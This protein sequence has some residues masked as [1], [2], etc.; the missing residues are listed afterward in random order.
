MSLESDSSDLSV[1]LCGEFRITA[2]LRKYACDLTLDP[3]TAN[4]YLILS[5]ENR[6]ITCM[7]QHQSYP[8]HPERFDECPQVLCGESLTGRCYWEF[9]W[10]GR[11]AIISVTYK[12]ISRKESRDCWFG[13]NDKSWSLYCSDYRFTVWHNKNFT[14]IPVICS[15]SKRVGVYVD[16]SAGTLSFYS[17]S[18][19][20]TLAHLHTF[21]TTFTEPL[22]AGFRLYLNSIVSLCDIKQPPVRN[23]SDTHTTRFSDSKPS[24]LNIHPLLNCQSCVHIADSDQWVQIEPSACTDEGGSKFRVSTD[25]GRYE[26]VRTRMRWVCDCDVTLQYCTVDGH[27]LNTELERLQCN[28]I[29]PVID[30]TVISGKLEEVHLPHYACLGESDPS[31]KDAVKVLTVKD[32]GITT[33]PVQL[34]R[35]HAK[36]VQPSFSLT[37]LIISWIMRVDEHCDLLLYMHSKVPL[38]LHVYFFPFDDC[39][40]EKVEKSEKSSY[41]IKHPRP[42]RPFRMK[43]PH[44]LDVSDALT[45]HPKEGITLRRET[46]PNYFKVTTRL[47][48]DLQMTLIRKE[49]KEEVWTAT[50]LKDELYRINPKRDEP[51]LNSEADKALFFDNHWPDLIQGVKNVGIIADRLCQQKIIHEEQY[52]EITQSLT[53]QESMRKICDIIRKHSDAVKAKFIS[54]LQKDELYL[55]EHLYDST[56]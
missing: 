51:R 14:D 15:S 26:C 45:I 46:P 43:T 40:K 7:F 53:S 48:N 5:D 35:F 37:T 52:S 22:Y 29:A 1:D 56:P 44:I 4:T 17:V 30:V 19:T 11:D 20:H 13:F 23:N 6:K 41:P 24:G 32:E 28:R 38:I 54:V 16:V 10:S 31:L 25:P 34:T 9:E 18:D 49:N 21:N 50:I 39:A 3:N 27:F 55:L 12:G 47:E 42:D 2:G 8:D 36:I 33:E